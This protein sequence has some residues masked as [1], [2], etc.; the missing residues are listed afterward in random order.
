MSRQQEL[1]SLDAVAQAQLVRRGEVTAVEL[2]E[3][4]ISRLEQVNPD[5]NAVITNRFE[6]ALQEAAGPIPQGPFAGVPFLL[7][8]LM[9]SLSGVRMTGGCRLLAENRADYDSELVVRLKR[10]GLIVIG[11]TNTPELGCH[12]TTEPELFGATRNPWDLTRSP[13]G[14]SGGSAAAV[15]AGVVPMAHGNDAGGSI[16]MPAACCGVFGLKPTR[17][18]NP[19]GP[20][21]GDRMGGLVVEHVLTRSVRDSAWVLDATSGPDV[22]DPY[23][24]APPERS[25]AAS[26]ASAPAVLA[27]G[28]STKTLKG[29]PA[30]PDCVA[31]VESTARLCAELGHEVSAD[32]PSVDGEVIEATFDTIFSAGMAAGVDR[33]AAAIG[34]TVT[35]GELEPLTGY[36]Y[37]KG[38]GVSASEYLRAVDTMQRVARQVAEFFQSRDIWLTPTVAEPPVP[39]GTFDFA[40]FRTPHDALQRILAFMPFTQ[41]VNATGQPAMSVPLS[42]NA[43]GLPIGVQFIGRYGDE[44]SLFQLAGQ[45]ERVRPWAQRLPPVHAGPR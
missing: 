7:K 44:A 12:A 20:D 15:S 27:I 43:A 28:F 42:W 3:A 18:R 34:R 45:L 17:G 24:A 35:A 16:R 25:F 29:E 26:A 31:A 6:E 32:E 13:G 41:I 30:H 19:L 38:R 4:A 40:N 8:D 9:A 33:V 22:G 1:W 37:E 36:M 39:L 10:A 14:S 2:V 5:L 23:W 21:A 11:L